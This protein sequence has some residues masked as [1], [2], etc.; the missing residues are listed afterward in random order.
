MEKAGQIE[1][2]DGNEAHH[3]VPQGDRRM[4]GQRDPSTAQNVLRQ[5][6][7]NLDSVENGAVLSQSFHRRIHTNAYYAYVE[8]NLRAFGTREEV[9][10]WLSRFSKQLTDADREF[11]KSGQ[12]PS[13]ITGERP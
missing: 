8:A 12:L 1:R 10:A 13:W 2:N 9:A 11:Q 5:F 4:T 3:M 6:G 7:I